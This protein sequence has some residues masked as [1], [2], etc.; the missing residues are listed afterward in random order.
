MKHIIV[1][2]DRKGGIGRGGDML[3]HLRAD[4]K[5][6][7]ALTMGNTLVMGRKTFESLP[8]G[9]L[10][11]RRNIVVTR[12]AGYAAAGIETAASLEEAYAMAADG[13]GE[14]FVI[15]GSQIYASALK[16]ADVLELTV[17]DADGESP[18]T[19]FPAIALDEFEVI[20]V[21]DAE[22]DPPAKF[23]TLRRRVRI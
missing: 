22:T 5:R 1:A 23:V 4:L 13:P 11:G 20:S 10:P 19:F 7:K 15:G 14:V 21:E 17:I 3:F 18:D 9:A 16:D 8:S 2:I 12:N 6:F